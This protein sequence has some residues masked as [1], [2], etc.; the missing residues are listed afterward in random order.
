M[1]HL[2]MLEVSVL[3]VKTKNQGRLGLPIY[4]RLQWVPYYSYTNT[5]VQNCLLCLQLMKEEVMNIIM[6]FMSIHIYTVYTFILLN[7]NTNEIILLHF[8]IKE[9]TLRYLKGLISKQLFNVWLCCTI[10]EFKRINIREISY[11]PTKTGV[12]WTI[13]FY[14]NHNF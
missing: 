5:K 13:Q 12:F 1:Y 10:F 3:S 9:M 8:N 7:F 2:F 4:A 6:T 14:N 11:Y